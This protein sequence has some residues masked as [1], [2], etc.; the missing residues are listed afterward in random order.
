[1][2]LSLDI[3]HLLP[4]GLIEYNPNMLICFCGSP[5]RIVNLRQFPME[6]VP[7]T[8][9]LPSKILVAIF[10]GFVNLEGW[11]VVTGTMEF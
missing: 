11:L 8:M 9:D 5:P 2:I 6:H 7:Y 3:V 4:T 10:H 1:M